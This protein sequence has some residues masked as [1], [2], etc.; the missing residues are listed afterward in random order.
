MF[1]FCWAT[2][3]RNPLN[4][5]CHWR[6]FGLNNQSLP[7]TCWMNGGVPKLNGKFENV[8]L[9]QRTFNLYRQRPSLPEIS[10]RPL[11]ATHVTSSQNTKTWDWQKDHSSWL[12]STTK[13]YLIESPRNAE[14][15][16]N[17]CLYLMIFST[18]IE[19]NSNNQIRF[20]FRSENFILNWF[21]M[22]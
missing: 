10:W 9:L 8:I 12:L 5:L 13:G 11:F 7:K 21:T 17:L 2:P 3:S 22:R 6:T 14:G 4:D 19:L 18:D 15:K 20:E 16:G 1:H